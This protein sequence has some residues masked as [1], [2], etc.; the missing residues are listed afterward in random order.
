[1]QSRKKVFLSL[2]SN[3]GNRIGNILKAIDLLRGL[4]EIRKVSTVYESEPWGVSDQPPFLNCVVLM[5]TSLL[6]EELLG[7]LKKIERIVGRK[8]RFR[9]G[10]REIDIDI[11]L[12]DDEVV[13][14]PNLSIP[15]PHMTDRDFVLYP[16]LE[17]EEVRDPRTGRPFRDSLR[18]LSLSLRPFCSILL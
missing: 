2:G 4:G 5:E 6:P 18:N 14:L 8:E 12:Y 3:V 17:L 15:H 16:L 13:E 9:W 11:L 7:E 10:P 1:M